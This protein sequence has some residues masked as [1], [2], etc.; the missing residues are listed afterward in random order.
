MT[1]APVFDPAPNN[2]LG[3]TVIDGVFASQAVDTSGEVL[4]VAGCDISSLATEGVAIWEHRKKKDAGHSPLDVLGKI[5]FAKKIHSLDDCTDER[6]RRFWAMVK[7]P[8]IYGKVRLYDGAGHPAALAL[9]AQIRDHVANGDK[10][11]CRFSID[12]STLERSP[13]PNGPRLARTV[14]RD[15]AVTIKPCNRT[16]D[17]GLV[18]DPQAEGLQRGEGEIGSC[19]V[20][21]EQA[22]LEKA[23]GVPAPAPEPAAAPPPVR[24]T[25]DAAAGALTTPT[26]TYY[27]HIPARRSD[28]ELDAYRRAAGDG[29][30]QELL[31]KARTSRA[32][33]TLLLA[34]GALPRAAIE[35][36]AAVSGATLAGRPRPR[37]GSLLELVKSATRDDVSALHEAVVR[38]R[39]DGPGLIRELQEGG[40]T[41]VAA[42]SFAAC[43]GY[44][45]VVPDRELVA[46]LF[47]TAPDLSSL[48]P[49]ADDVPLR[50][51]EGFCRENAAADGQDV[52]DLAWERWL[53]EPGYRQLRGQPPTQ[54]SRVDLF[55]ASAPPNGGSPE[56]A[57]DLHRQWAG[58]FGEL[59]AQLL[60]F[61]HLFP[62]VCSC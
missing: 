23:E 34:A 45:A 29:Q 40:S 35:H 48:A 1:D 3:D 60:Y 12:G 53:A 5:V 33:A 15:V 39:L 6:Q 37:T 30:V 14:A 19:A 56:A 44:P 31:G 57:V 26:G 17:S 41:P 54:A 47:P 61:A 22:P 36:A 18:H 7:L 13:P 11:I 28:A 10:I 46:A 4:D 58:R 16:C 32:R 21:L 49:F 52:T 24:C 27:A 50:S 38:R 43:C 42:R 20:V 9:A 51:L 25:F 8:L 55:A 62:A 2:Q 59:G